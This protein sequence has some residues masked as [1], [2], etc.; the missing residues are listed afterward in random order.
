MTG[1]V[2]FATRVEAEV[3]IFTLRWALKRKDMNGRR[4]KHRKGRPV[5]KRAYYCEYCKGFHVTH[6]EK[7]DFNTYL[8]QREKRGE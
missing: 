8:E 5:A 2:R 4:I 1:K 6:W 3:V 7:S